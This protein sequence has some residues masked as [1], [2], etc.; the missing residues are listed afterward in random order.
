MQIIIAVSN[1]I[2]FASRF[3]WRWEHQNWWHWKRWSKGFWNLQHWWWK[4]IDL[5][6]S[7]KLF[8]KYTF[9]TFWRPKLLFLQIRIGFWNSN[10]H[11]YLD[12][13]SYIKFKFCTSASCHICRHRT[14]GALILH[15]LW[16][17]KTTEKSWPLTTNSKFSTICCWM[18][19]ML[20]LNCYF[21]V[22]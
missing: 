20:H 14:P 8:G 11:T 18:A 15:H 5:V 16:A 22:I 19:S 9:Y 7:G 2:F 3:F 4:R 17:A 12:Y 1:H 6:W 13:D 10:I 21:L